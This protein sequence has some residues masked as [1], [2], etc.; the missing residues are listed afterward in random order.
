MAD[1]LLEVELLRLRTGSRETWPAE[2]LGL[3]YRHSDLPD[4][5]VVISATM[6]LAVGDPATLRAEIEHIRA[7]RREHQPLNEPNCGSVFTN[8]VGDSAGRLIDV[9]GCKGLAVGGARVSTLHANFIVTRPG[10]RATD[11][12]TLIELVIRRVRASAGIELHAEVQRLGV[13]SVDEDRLTGQGTAG[14]P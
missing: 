8:P 3:A 1:H 12:A 11:V 10:A 7:W 6:T 5:A 9:A 13:V 14:E 4:D 2:A